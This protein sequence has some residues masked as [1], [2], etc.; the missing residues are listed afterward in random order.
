VLFRI[1][2]YNTS[3]SINSV[4]K[5]LYMPCNGIAVLSARTSADIKT[6]TAL[7]S[8]RQLQAAV[9]AIL[10][11]S[12]TEK[13]GDTLTIRIP[14]AQAQIF[15]GGEIAA[16]GAQRAKLVAA[17]E[18]RILPTLTGLAAQ[19][20]TLSALQNIYQLQNLKRAPNGAIV[21]E[22]NL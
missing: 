10:P 3:N 2:W 1:F 6:I 9:L 4:R 7:F 20:K 16:Q 22:I 14:G 8:A 5:E 15:P 11:D 17:I 13:T 12:A 19:T 18:D 21:A